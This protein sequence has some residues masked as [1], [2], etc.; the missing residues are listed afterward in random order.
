MVFFRPWC[1]LWDA[2]A[3]S[4]HGATDASSAR[5]SGAGAEPASPGGEDRTVRSID[6]LCATRADDPTRR[7]PLD[8]G[9]RLRGRTASAPRGTA[10]RIRRAPGDLPGVLPSVH[11]RA[12]EVPE[13]VPRIRSRRARPRARSGARP[14]AR[15]IRGSSPGGLQRGPPP[16][17]PRQEVAG[18]ALPEGRRRG[19]G[20]PAGERSSQRPED[21]G[22][23]GGADSRREA[24]EGRSL[25]E[26]SP[27]PGR[28]RL[29]LPPTVRQDR[30]ERRVL[31]QPLEEERRSAFRPLTHRPPRSGDGPR[32]EAVERGASPPSTPDPGRRG[33][34]GL[35]TTNLRRTTLGGHS[36]L[37]LGGGLGRGGRGVPPLSD[38]R[39]SRGA[40][41]RGGGPALRDAL[42]DRA[43]VQ[44]AE[45]ALCAGRVPNDE[46]SRGGGAD[47]V[48]AADTGGEPT[49][50]HARTEAGVR[51]APTPLHPVALRGKLPPRGSP[52]PHRDALRSRALEG[53]EESVR[54]E[55]VPRR[56]VA[57]SSHQATPIPR[58]VVDVTVVNL[59]RMEDSRSQWGQ[60]SP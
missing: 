56:G 52:H 44:G 22:P 5:G 32:G 34:A 41:R 54:P 7:L 31:R 9:T 26:G 60:L 2:P 48:G 30:G 39:R 21:R 43:G 53:P 38:E 47:L 28:L 6:R 17:E 36:T 18:H 29:L 45:V 35:P 13:A 57:G 11:P 8:A 15:P 16:C 25:G 49:S 1:P 20:R 59:C 14:E 3:S 10:G 23:R 55:H 24:P 46:R 19:E 37:S 27:P 33:R 51:G 40:E 50:P 12:L 58:G 42:G 4:G